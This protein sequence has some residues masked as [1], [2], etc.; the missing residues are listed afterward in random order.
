MS[1]DLDWLSDLV[2]GGEDEAAEE[3]SS[4]EILPAVAPFASS[5]PEPELD[6]M[7]DLRSEIVTDEEEPT[8]V[9]ASPRPP[10]TFGG[11]KPPQLFFL[12][13]LLFLDV[14]VIGLLF[15]VML[16]RIVFPV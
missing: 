3:A 7:D 6:L 9:G 14:A 8:V 13:V 5:E 12:S 16:G 1:D 10:R 15:L 4:P 2:A 11:L